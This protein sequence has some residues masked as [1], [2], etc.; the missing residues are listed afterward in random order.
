LNLTKGT[1]AQWAA[2]TGRACGE[3]SLCCKLLH[4]KELDKPANKWCPHCAPGKGG[5]TIWGRTPDIC[6]L[7]FC[8]WRIT[9]GFGDEWFPLKS[10]MVVSL[11][12]QNAVQV[13]MITVDPLHS[14]IWRS[15]PYYRQLRELARRGRISNDPMVVIV[16][17]G[18]R[19]WQV[20]IDGEREIADSEVVVNARQARNFDMTRSRA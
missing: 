7:Y 5:C 8:G 1:S 18:A 4:V 14:E 6:R 2:Q 12:Q 17:V 3:C 19:V 20:D 9:R 11:N 15:E 13:L 16:R 10:H